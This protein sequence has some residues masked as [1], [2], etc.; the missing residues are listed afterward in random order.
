MMTRAER[1][2]QFMAFDAMKGLTEALKAKE[3]E[4]ERTEKRELSEDEADNVSRALLKA[5]E[6]DEIDLVFYRG[7]HEISVTAK[8]D[9]IDKTYKYMM[10]GEDKIFF[11]DVCKITI[12]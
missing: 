6:G 4:H 12:K 5:V 11:D 1:A 9:L 10:L 2:K 8:I 7:G 3:E